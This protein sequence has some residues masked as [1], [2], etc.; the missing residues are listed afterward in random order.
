MYTKFFLREVRRRALRKRVWFSALDRLERGIFNLS[1]SIVDRVKSSFLGSVL[2]KI[3]ICL[4]DAMKGDFVKMLE[5]VGLRRAHELAGYASSWGY[6]NTYH[7][8]SSLDF[9]RYLTV[10]E[11][12]AP[13]GWGS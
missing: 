13:Q 6:G 5:S 1:C 3:I 10:L 2:L 7:W 8:L 12:H 4:R 9:A 11:F